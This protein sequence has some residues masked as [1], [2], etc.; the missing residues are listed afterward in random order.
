[1]QLKIP[2]TYN[3]YDVPYGNDIPAEQIFVYNFEKLPSRFFENK[4][5]DFRV[6]NFFKE[7]GFEEIN[8]ITTKRRND[9]SFKILSINYEKKVFA[10]FS[11]NK[12]EDKN[13]N[14][15][16]ELLYD[17]SIGEIGDQIDLTKIVEF[18]KPPKRA[19][20]NLVK[21]E[22]GHLDTQE[23]E[24]PTPDIDLE[25]NYGA[26]FKKV[27]NLIVE[28]LNKE[29]DKGIILL[30]GDP[31]TGKTSYIK[32]LT[33]LITDKDILFI[34]PS[35]AEMLSEPSII[36]FLMDHKNSILIIE[37]AE[38]VISDRQINGSSP[39]VSNILN[40]TDGILG[41]CLSI[42]I[43]ATFNM[44]REKIDPALL[45][46]GRLIAEHKFTK[47][48]VE[49]SN[50]LLKHINKDITVTESLALADIYNID[51]EEYKTTNNK[52]KIGF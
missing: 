22:M 20:I 1:M 35:M 2:T 29:N 51:A 49:E 46:K 17:I 24:L 3:L 7:N 10:I 13:D 19:Q 39:G 8:R 43:I 25:L 21:S 14:I 11:H 12:Y 36:P 18:E 31:G 5:Y 47:L 50:N 52:T 4:K 23:Y 34:P 48:S 38:R 28:R 37:D 30:H 16:L 15:S 27:H 45:R 26:S 32:Y 9:D 6:I 44:V 40:L 42:Q 33:K 41:D